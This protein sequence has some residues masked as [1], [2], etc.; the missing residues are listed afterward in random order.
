M[1]LDAVLDEFRLRVQTQI[2]KTLYLVKVFSETNASMQ[3][4]VDNSKK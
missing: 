2:Y 1:A 3:L 4:P